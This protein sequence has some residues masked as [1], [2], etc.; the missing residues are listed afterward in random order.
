MVGSKLTAVAMAISP[1][2]IESLA[3][4]ESEEL[5]KVTTTESISLQPSLPAMTYKTVLPL[6]IYVIT[7]S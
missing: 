4:S 7:E 1:A 3:E 6:G 5:T 2:Q